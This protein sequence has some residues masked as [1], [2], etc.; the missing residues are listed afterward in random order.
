VTVRHVLIGLN[1]IAVLAIVGYLIW[2][3]LSPKRASEETMPANLTP[4]LADDELE[5]R[6]LERVQGWALLFAAVVAV[7]LPL[8]W[9][10]EPSRQKESVS[11]FSN[12]AAHR[13]EILFSNSSMLTYDPT[14]SLQCANCH[15][16]TGGGGQVPTFVNG[17]A[18]VWEAP[19]LNTVLER[20]EED[21]DC[22]MPVDDQP[23]G[24]VCDV[25]N[26]ITYGR[27]GTPM[28]GWGVAGGGPKNVQSI[29]DL[30]AYLRTIQLKPAQI[31]A[32]EAATITAARSTDPNT[33]CPQYVSCPAVQE[34]AA[35]TTLTTDTG[36]LGDARTGLQKA[37]KQSDAT[38]AELTDSC[39]SIIAQVKT[40]PK[41]VDPDQATACGTYTTAA[42]QV[43]TDQNALAWTEDW[44]KR[45]VNVSDGQILFEANC[46]RCHTQGWST[47]DS[48]VPAD[49]PGGVDGLGSPAGGGGLGGG[50]G[51]NLRNGDEIRRFG[52]DP[53]GG[54]AAQVDFVSLGSIPFKPYGNAGIG[55]G[56]MPGFAGMLT[57]D[58]ISEI[59]SYERYC[60]DTSTFLATEPVCK[61]GTTSRVPATT[62]TTV[63]A[64]G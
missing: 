7:A 3:V 48:S 34:D 62:T 19:P 51:P 22:A 42:M 58:Q 24:T 64:A 1:L 28:Q 10:H 26:I 5:S 8:Y 46:A 2:A 21:P 12:N 49:Q 30:V 4:F 6:R 39:N 36:K 44:A 56:R 52:D 41:Q 18:V 55:S 61:T 31:K 47:F 43:T 40:D 17:N 13:G 20:F 50:I 11:Y 53:S 59:V 23:D 37:L 15:G 38:D 16:T 27:P 60:L 35:R 57:K 25:T 63:K 33:S 14:Q 54:F 32:Q 9:L 45:R 29:Q